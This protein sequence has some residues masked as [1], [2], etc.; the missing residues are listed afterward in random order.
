[1]QFNQILTEEMYNQHQLWIE[2]HNC[3]KRL[4]LSDANLYSVDLR[5]TNLSI[6][7]LSNTNLSYSDLSN[8][9]LRRSNLFGADL[10]RSNL[11]DADL[12]CSNLSDA[13][14]TGANLSGA[15]IR[16]CKPDGIRIKR[17][18]LPLYEVNILDNQIVSIGCKQYHIDTWKSFSDDQIDQMDTDALQWW[19]TYKQSIFDFIEEQKMRFN[20]IL[21]E[22]MYNQHQLWIEDHNCGKRLELINANLS[23]AD[24]SCAVLCNANLS[25]AD[26]RYAKLSGA[27]LYN[28]KLSGANLCNADLNHADLRY[29]N[30]SNAHLSR[31]KLRRANLSGVDIRFCTPDGN[32]IKSID[33][34]KY[35]VNILDNHTITIGCQQHHLDQWKSFSDE[36]IDN[37]DTYTYTLQWWNTHKQSIFDFIEEQK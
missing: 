36:Q 35:D 14:L 12:T 4:D 7:E 3:G 5:Y 27:D 19:N 6:A 30:L 22:E 23:G 29:A 25:G 13:V 9:Y 24:L 11:S 18:N 8:S 28:A 17:I 15:S 1:M 33:L 32:R 20:H 2:N 37:M 26:L 34:P 10:R 21:T 16:F 31:A